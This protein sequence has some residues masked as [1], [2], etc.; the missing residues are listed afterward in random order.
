MQLLVIGL[1][2]SATLIIENYAGTTCIVTEVAALQQDSKKCS[3]L[4]LNTYL[5]QRL[6][7]QGK[8]FDFIKNIGEYSMFMLRKS[9]LSRITDLDVIKL[10]HGAQVSITQNEL[11]AKLP[12]FEWKR[13]DRITFTVA[14]NPNLDTTKL[15]KDVKA[16]KMKNAH[17]QLP[18]GEFSATVVSSASQRYHDMIAGNQQISNEPPRSFG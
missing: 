16:R 6:V 17:I 8:F 18:F 7:K 12:K 15:L 14:D 2:F 1:L 11:L 10:H 4:H 5:D 9:N 3:V 13:G